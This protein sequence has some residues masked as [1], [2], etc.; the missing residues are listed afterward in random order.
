MKSSGKNKRMSAVFSGRVQGVGFRFTVSELAS[1]F[2]VT[3]FIRNQW[4]GTVELIAEGAFSELID[5]LHAIRAS[6]LERFIMNEQIEWYP[7][8][9]EFSHFGIEL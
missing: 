1:A 2:S 9:G 3:G 5:F 8:T 7:A 4:N 6:R